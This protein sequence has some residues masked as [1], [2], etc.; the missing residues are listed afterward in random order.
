MKS[1]HREIEER[2]KEI[3]GQGLYRKL[4][5]PHGLDFSSNDYLG[6]SRDPT[7]H[8][9]ILKR[10]K[11][12]DEMYPFSSPASRLLRGNT[13]R[14]RAVEERLARFKGT[15]AA[16]LFPTGYQANIGVLTTLLGPRD[17]V[18]SDAQNHA[19]IIDGL[20]LSRC[21]K[22]I[23]PHCG[24]QAVKDALV[25]PYPGG[26]TC[27]VTESLFSMDGD[28]APLD[29]YIELVET[30]GA[31]LIVDDAHATGVFGQQ[32]GS[33]LTEQFGIERRTLA[34]I[35][36]FGK[37]FGL[38]GA[39]VAGPKI[40]I[41]Y[42]INRCRSF[43]FTTAV[44]PV[45]LLA[46]EAALD[47]SS[48]QAERRQRVCALADRLRDQLKT[49]GV[50]T[51]QSSGP[52]VPVIVGENERALELAE[53]LQRRGFDIRAI[54]PPTVPPGTARLRISVHAD[55]QEEEIDDLA[56]A[57]IEALRGERVKQVGR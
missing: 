27:L 32:R 25:A 11:Q 37:A 55:H 46:V 53:R 39:F 22:I 35:S 48:A 54:R 49:E 19:S 45:L 15:E 51:L 24:L 56:A 44:P 4:S 10:L 9:A 18:L 12:A 50:N 43:I 30:Y 21:Q 26:R 1:F 16:L 40:V 57:T 6:L 5:D 33:G 7:L 2:L 38:F 47:I 34:I 28:V 23:F 52:I 8:A 13:P 14:H 3:A 17:R 36:T 41:E 42:L 31:Y 20:R 29:A